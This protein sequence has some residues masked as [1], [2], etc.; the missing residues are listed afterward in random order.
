MSKIA[1]AVFNRKGGVGKTT[2]SVILAEIALVRGKSLLAVDLDPSRNF[3][4]ALGFLKDS[5]FKDNFRVKT[6]LDDSDE[7]APEEWIV[8][9]CP[10]A[11]NPRD[12]NDPSKHAMDFADITVIPVRPDYFS[13]TPLG[14]IDSLA[15]DKFGKSRSQLPL[16]KLGFDD[17]LMSRV[18]NQVI[19]ESGHP[20]AEDITLHKSIPYNITSGK[21]WSMGLAARFRLP[22]ESLYLKIE[23]AMHRLTNGITDVYEVWTSGGDAE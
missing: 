12:D 4:S 20:I 1:V 11:L 17:S 3:S 23:N 5:G 15:E 7:G 18:T 22:Y 19:A 14:L 16:L 9:D 6:S 10:P 2:I 8:I 13:L 21:I